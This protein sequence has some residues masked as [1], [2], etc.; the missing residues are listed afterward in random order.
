MQPFRQ[1]WF[2]SIFSLVKVAPLLC[3]SNFAPLRCRTWL[4]QPHMSACLFWE[5]LYGVRIGPPTCTDKLTVKINDH[6]L[7]CSNWRRPYWDWDVLLP[8][9]NF[10]PCGLRLKFLPLSISDAVIALYSI[11]FTVASSIRGWCSMRQPT[12]GCWVVTAVLVK[13]MHSTLLQH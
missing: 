2:H 11:K 3:Q 7:F 9:K 4:G 1:L 12:P 13:R 8:K 6:D 10:V 5:T